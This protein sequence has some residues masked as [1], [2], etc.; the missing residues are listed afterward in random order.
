[1]PVLPCFKQRLL[2]GNR[3][4]MLL[5]GMQYAGWPC[6]LYQCGCCHSSSMAVAPWNKSKL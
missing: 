4:L 5:V 3:L 6:R 2:A 1:M